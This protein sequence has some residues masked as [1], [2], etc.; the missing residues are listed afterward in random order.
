MLTLLFRPTMLRKFIGQGTF[1]NI[2][3]FLKSNNHSVVIIG[4][5]VLNQDDNGRC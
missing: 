1:Q 2:F 5:T 3:F 4:F